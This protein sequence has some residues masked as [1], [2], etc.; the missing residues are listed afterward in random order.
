MPL[1][2]LETRGEGPEQGVV[3]ALGRHLHLVPADLGPGGA[4][5][6]RPGRGREQLPAET[7]AEQRHVALEQ[8]SQQRLLLGDPAVP[9]A[10]VDVHR[11]AE[12]EDGVVAE[13]I[14][15]RLRPLRQRPLV[16]LPAGVGDRLGEDAGAGVALMD[17]REDPHSVERTR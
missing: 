6:L 2:G 3:F 4:A 8:L 10:F 9:L 11:P 1:V 15:R 5:R 12:D 7:E 16:E 13:R 17:D 14:G